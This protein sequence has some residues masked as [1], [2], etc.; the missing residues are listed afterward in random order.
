VDLDNITQ[1]VF[2]GNNADV[3]YAR[4]LQSIL[5]REPDIVMVGECEDRE[6]AQ[7]ATR[8]AADDRKIYLGLHAKDSFD[9][10]GKY[11]TFADDA[12][13]ASKGLIGILNQRLIRVLCTNCRESFK[14]DPAML[15]KLNLPGDKIECFHRPPTKPMLD[16]KGREVPCPQCQGTG[17]VGRTGL[18]ELL[19]VDPAVAQLIAEA[20]PVAKIK[21]QCRKNRM[22]YLQEEGLLK[23]IDGTTS[24]NEILR[25]A[26]SEG[27]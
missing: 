9:A 24:I 7:V 15:K 3:N 1:R 11:L 4:M 17:Y 14:P 16:K 6:T 13:T 5:R 26:K 8:A 10:L 22:H 20:A 25:G 23:V 18:F 19:V 12:K 27:E 2:E 21:I